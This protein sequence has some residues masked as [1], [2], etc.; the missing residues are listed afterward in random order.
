MDE[1]KDSISELQDA[2]KFRKHPLK[3]NNQNGKMKI[4]LSNDL[5][6]TISLSKEET[7]LNKS[8]YQY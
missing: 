7:D 5:L 6:K 8:G 1:V 4:L 2:T 3:H